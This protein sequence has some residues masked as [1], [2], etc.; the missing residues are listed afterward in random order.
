[1]SDSDDD[2]MFDEKPKGKT[3]GG[4]SA[5]KPP[6]REG[7][8]GKKDPK[9]KIKA[10]AAPK[11]LTG[12][13]GEKTAGQLKNDEDAKILKRQ[14]RVLGVISGKSAGENKEH[15]DG[16]R[17][18]IS[19]VIRKHSSVKPVE[20]IKKSTARKNK[21]L[22]MFPGLVSVVQEGKFGQLFDMDGNPK[23]DIEFPTGILRMLGAHVHTKTKLM[24][25]QP[26]KGGK[27]MLAQDFFEHM[28]VFS[29]HEWLGAPDQD[30]T[31]DVPEEAYKTIH[32]DYSY[33][34][35]A[36]AT[37]QSTGGSGSILD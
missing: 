15:C 8:K 18:R 7:S 12:K 35:G 3:G 30:P 36:A 17:L 19:P 37:S 11:D 34:G 10:T 2:A 22:F 9:E 16:S 26:A 25:L 1:M 6:A 13:K 21:V 14:A 29:Q 4:S 27:R 33:D 20:I 31:K 23:L 32:K 5:K 24:T 28:V